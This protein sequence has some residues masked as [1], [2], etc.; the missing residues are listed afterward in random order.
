MRAFRS[1][2]VA[3]AASL[4]CGIASAEVPAREQM[5]CPV[6]GETFT[7]LGYAVYSTYGQ[8]LDGKPFGST[9][10]P[11]RIPVCP[12]GVVIYKAPEDFSEA[13]IAVLATFIE[14]PE[15]RTMAEEHSTYYRASRL[16]RA[17]GEP[18]STQAWLMLSASWQV[19]QEAERFAA[20]QSGFLALADEASTQL[21]RTSPEWW[22]LQFR[23]ANAE[24]Q[25]GRFDA[26]AARLSGL[27]VDELAALQLGDGES[28]DDWRAGFEGAVATLNGLIAARDASVEPESLRRR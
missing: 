9:E 23:A 4:V 13:E 16:A 2:F 10:F 15:F 28:V 1:A 11:L 22:I 26:A 25:L 3:C 19:D 12:N 27:P 17:A 18:A 6:G 20:Y 5:V 24:R 8:R 14:T 21:S 7:H